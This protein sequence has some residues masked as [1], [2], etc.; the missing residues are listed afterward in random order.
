MMG[1]V[2]RVFSSGCLLWGLCG[3]AAYSAEPGAKLLQEA[4]VQFVPSERESSIA[5]RFRLS[6]HAFTAREESLHDVSKRIAITQV[7]FPSPVETASQRNNTVHCEYYRPRGEGKRPAVIV[8]HILGGDFP[9]ARVFA[10]MFAE[11]GVAALFLKMPYY[12]ERRDPDNR[13]RMISDNPNETVE[14]MTQAILDI[15]RASAFLAQ[16]DE[17]DP[18][19]IGIFGIS[20]GGITGALAATAEPRLKNICLLLAGGDIGRVAWESKELDKL[21]RKW[22][23]GGG[24]KSEFLRVLQQVD[25]VQYGHQV[26]GRRILM[27]N[28]DR[29]ELIPKECTEA[30]W[31]SFGR[32]KLVWYEGGHY[33]VIKHLPNALHTAAAFFE[34]AA[35]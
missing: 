15:R 10:N 11:H 23:E 29:D 5:E 22:V 28:A 26:Q 18:D 1:F 16:R 33:S 27:L 2:R 6:A 8:L 19:Q 30:L 31:T 13:R 4:E 12:G 14:G 34:N 3:A 35:P 24:T 17:I 9:L 7:T 25:P 21:R 20:L 32:P